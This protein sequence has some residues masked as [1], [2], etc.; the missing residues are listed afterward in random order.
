MKQEI[1]PETVKQVIETIRRATENLDAKTALAIHTYLH[2][3]MHKDDPTAVVAGLMAA[4]YVDKN[5]MTLEPPAD[6][7]IGILMTLH[8]FEAVANWTNAEYEWALNNI[9]D[10]EVMEKAKEYLIEEDMQDKRDAEVSKKEGFDD[11]LMGMPDNIVK[12]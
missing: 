10:K 8:G 5:E 1:A 7:A 12:H 11:L 2:A 9:N 4:K 3:L 6:C